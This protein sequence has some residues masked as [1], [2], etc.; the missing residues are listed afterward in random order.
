MKRR[1]WASDLSKRRAKSAEKQLERAKS[2]WSDSLA[3]IGLSRSM[4]PTKVR[5]LRQDY[6]R[7]ELSLQKWRELEAEYE[8]RKGEKRA[9]AIRVEQLYQDWLRCTQDEAERLSSYQGKRV[10]RL[11]R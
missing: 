11:V 1:S 7:L 4:S 5:S 8:I 3:G 6:D 9:I 2:Q 10:S